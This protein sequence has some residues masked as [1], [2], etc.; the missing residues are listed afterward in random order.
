MGAGHV[1]IASEEFHE[2]RSIFHRLRNGLAVHGQRDFGH[3][4]LPRV[5]LDYPYPI[6]GFRVAKGEY[7]AAS[8]PAGASDWVAGQKWVRFQG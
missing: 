6:T 1:E 5:F 7:D 8:A 3:A 4:I 2:K